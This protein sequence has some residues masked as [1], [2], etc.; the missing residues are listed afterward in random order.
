M[1]EVSVDTSYLCERLSSDNIS[2]NQW[3]DICQFVEVQRLRH[4]DHPAI[5][6]MLIDHQAGL[7]FNIKNQLR[8]T[9]DQGEI[10]ILRHGNIMIGI[11]CVEHTAVAP[12]LTIGGIRCWL[13]DQH[14]QHNQVTRYLLS[15]NLLWSKLQNAAAMMLTFN[16]Y[17]KQIY[18]AIVRKSSAKAAGLGKVWSSWWNDCLA[19]PNPVNIRHTPQWCVLKPLDHYQTL[20]IAEALIKT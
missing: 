19:I 13:D 2:A 7:L 11:S 8:W 3:Q 18:D 17:N 1:S 16:D 5:D 9:K 12:Q 14:R 6:N 15:S 4:P 10:T 20:V